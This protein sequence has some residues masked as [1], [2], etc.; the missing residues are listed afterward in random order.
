VSQ[1]VDANARQPRIRQCSS[2]RLVRSA[3]VER[4][5]PPVCEDYPGVLPLS[6]RGP[7]LGFPDPMI[8]QRMECSFRGQTCLGRY[9]DFCRR[10]VRTFSRRVNG[11]GDLLGLL[12]SRRKRALATA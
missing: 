9:L 12:L 7:A 5:S 6:G 3:L 2:Q 1:I 8:A 4:A 11:S 10:V